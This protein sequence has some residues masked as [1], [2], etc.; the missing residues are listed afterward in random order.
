MPV[1]DTLNI[2]VNMANSNAI[3]R[4]MWPASMPSVYTASTR[5]AYM[6]A[7]FPIP[8]DPKF[9]SHVLDVVSVQYLFHSGGLNITMIMA[10]PW[11]T[12]AAL[13]I[14]QASM[15]RA[16]VQ[17]SHVLRCVIYSADLSIWYV[18]LS[19]LVMSALIFVS[20]TAR[21]ATLGPGFSDRIAAWLLLLLSWE[22]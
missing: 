20:I 4:R 10:W 9:F 16:K 18:L 1:V 15:R 14:F 21:A 8:P 7:V 17:R 13:M 3:G 6:D 12:F 2:A 11:L 5:Q 19:G 22:D